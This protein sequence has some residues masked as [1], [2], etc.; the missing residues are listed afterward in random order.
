MQNPALFRVFVS[1]TFQDFAVERAGL[2]QRVFPRL[3]DYCAERGARF[4]AVDLRWGIAPAAARDQRTVRICLEEIERCRRLSD[5]PAFL[6]LVGDRY[7]W[8]PLP[9]PVE[10]GTFQ[11]LLGV[12]TS[13]ERREVERWYQRDNNEI[14]PAYHLLARTADMDDDEWTGIEDGL[15]AVLMGAARTAGL[16]DAEIDLLFASATHREIVAGALGDDEAAARAV[17]CVRRIDGAA[18]SESAAATAAHSRL[19]FRLHQAFGSRL[20]TYRWSLGDEAAAQQGVTDLLS[21]IEADLRA[22][23]DFNLGARSTRDP[24]TENAQTHLRF[25][26]ATAEGVVGRDT[27]VADIQA[28][29]LRRKAE[30]PMI[31]TGPG[32]IGKTAVMATGAARLA[33][34][35]TASLLP[36]FIGATA[37]NDLRETLTD[38][39]R[40]LAENVGISPRNE[41]FEPDRVASVMTDLLAGLPADRPV[42]LMIDGYDQLM[43]ADEALHLDWLPNPLPAHVR[44]ILSMRTASV[45]ALRLKQ[46]L[47]LDLPPMAE[48]DA[49]MLLDR[50]LAADG[51]RLDGE[52]RAVLLESF[53]G[54]CLPLQLKL[55]T[56]AVR[57]LPSGEPV[58][59]LAAD[60]PGLVRTLIAGLSA[61]SAHGPELAGKALAL[62]AA[63][64]F[65]LSDGEIREML[66]HDPEVMAAFRR[67]S[68]HHDWHQAGLPPIVWSRLRHDLGPYLIE[69]RVEGDL[70]YR[71]FHLEFQTVAVDDL[72]AGD[73]KGTVHRQLATF[74]AEPAG[75]QLFLGARGGAPRALRAVME[76]PYQLRAAGDH[77]AHNDYLRDFDALMAKCAA[78]RVFDLA[79]D[80]LAGAEAPATAPWRQ[81][82]VANASLLGGAADDWPAYKILFQFAEEQPAGSAPADA[83]ERWLD[84]RH[85][86]WPRL[87]HTD[88]AAGG[89]GAGSALVFAEHQGPVYGARV[90]RNNTVASW[91]EYGKILVWNP[92]TGRLLHLLDSHATGNRVFGAL[93]LTDGTLF[94][95]YDDG[96]TVHWDPV[97]GR[98]LSVFKD[99]PVAVAVKAVVPGQ[100]FLSVRHQRHF[101]LVPVDE[102]GK[103]P[104]VGEE[105]P[106]LVGPPPH[107]GDLILMLDCERLTVVLTD[108]L[109]A[110]GNT[111]ARHP[112]FVLGGHLLPDGRLLAWSWDRVR[113]WNAVQQLVED[114]SGGLGNIHYV[115]LGAGGHL[116]IAVEDGQPPYRRR[117]RRLYWSSQS[118]VGRMVSDIAG[119]LGRPEWGR[120][121]EP[122]PFDGRRALTLDDGS[123]VSWGEGETVEFRRAGQDQ[124]LFWHGHSGWPWGAIQLSATE[125]VTWG[126]DGRVIVW[127]VWHGTPRDVASQHSSEVHGVA[128]LPDGRLLSWS[129]DHL[130]RV[131]RPGDQPSATAVGQQKPFKEI[132][133]LGA[134]RIVAWTETDALTVWDAV[135]GRTVGHIKRAP[136]TIMGALAL[137]GDRLVTTAYNA[138]CTLWD[139]PTGRAITSFRPGV[140]VRGVVEV[141]SNRFVAWGD[142]SSPAIFDATS[143]AELATLDG[144]DDDV[145][146]AALLPDGSLATW[147]KDQTLRRWDLQSRRSVVLRGEGAAEIDRLQP[148]A[149]GLFASIPW[150]GDEPIRIWN[151]ERCLASCRHDD[152]G[153]TM[154]NLLDID[155]RRLLGWTA[156]GRLWLWRKADGAVLQCFEGHRDRV[157]GALMTDDGLLCSWS[158]MDGTLRRWDLDTGTEV[159]SRDIGDA[160]TLGEAARRTIE[161]TDMPG[162]LYRMGWSTGD[163]GTTAVIG[164]RG[165][166]LYWLG[167]QPVQAHALSADGRM[168][169]VLGRSDFVALSVFLGRREITLADL[170]RATNGSEKT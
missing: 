146:G 6:F 136:H 129:Q 4:E 23:I 141:S 63:S 143:G 37:G 3:T 59:P 11:R 111:F 95:W 81:L 61:E 19:N 110:D 75:Y 74:F 135:Q 128:V 69:S 165:V 47:V 130:C 134:E 83:A 78:G 84:D 169:V 68:V 9:A 121:K 54:H 53:R 72:L 26:A 88:S 14:P 164:R 124:A 70:L 148:L 45:H 5:G 41:A 46:R 100:Q 92:D 79:A 13:D 170:W 77:A 97:G 147:S 7:G 57:E 127:G 18:V 114:L 90:L 154:G 94:T 155:A 30:G 167:R 112:E 89:E 166:G 40:D 22:L 43:P 91:D 24:A 101:R 49:G 162:P 109:T 85:V 66:G 42:V 20:K 35:D 113:L 29:A 103:V 168:T 160:A 105:P 36:R 67:R 86:D 51:R 106:V 123:S 158:H 28:Y 150:D 25:A 139:L 149:D 157:S 12:M 60:V 131:W 38:L 48:V 2:Q 153:Y 151:R 126:G 34:D 108:E 33:D 137:S 122:A 56:A 50:W 21:G 80:F 102:N 152:R 15:R 144:H 159:E 58:P 65:G 62:I 132:R 119:R 99:Q 118:A 120:R 104:S 142:F 55:A 82:V 39:I 52:Q 76:R 32:G 125:V 31:L 161:A 93:E 140:Y 117:I 44:V 71:F 27:A 64:R 10:A 138:P 156:A 145:C 96:V 115:S 16:T 8:Q 98:R 107:P 116:T 87:R 133:R 73:R 163:Y 17:G 1:S